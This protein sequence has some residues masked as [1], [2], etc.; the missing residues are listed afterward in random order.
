M[1]T[2]THQDKYLFLALIKTKVQFKFVGQKL[3]LSSFSK[4]R[5]T[6]ETVVDNIWGY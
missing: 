6:Y 1:C 5:K 2:L 3:K 4:L